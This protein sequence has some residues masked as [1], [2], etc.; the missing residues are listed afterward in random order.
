MNNEWEKEFVKLVT[1]TT[2]DKAAVP[3]QWIDFIQ[4]LLDAQREEL[5]ITDEV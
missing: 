2:P 3:Q 1:G 4:S 5:P